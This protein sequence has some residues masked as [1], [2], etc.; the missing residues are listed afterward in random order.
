MRIRLEL[1]AWVL[2]SAAAHCQAQ[3]YSVIFTGRLLGQFRYPE[4]QQLN[5]PQCPGDLPSE[6]NDPL[7]KKFRDS[8]AE[9]DRDHQA[10]RVAVGDTFAPFFLS[11]LMYDRGRSAGERWVHKEQYEFAESQGAWVRADKLQPSDESVLLRGGGRVPA[12]NVGCF[13]RLVQFDAIVP[14][15][16]DFYFGAERLRELKGFLESSNPQLPDFY[17]PVRMLGSNLTM[18]PVRR[19]PGQPPAAAK[20][21]V[22]KPGTPEPQAVIPAVVLPWMRAIRIKNAITITPPSPAVPD[23][24]RLFKNDDEDC[25]NS[26]LGVEGARAPMGRCAQRELTLGPYT[27][28]K[29]FS[30]V[31]IAFPDRPPET[32]VPVYKGNG[33]YVDF[34]IAG[35][36]ANVP[37]PLAS[38]KLQIARTGKSSIETPINVELPY[39]ESVSSG[40]KPWASPLAAG[41]SVAVFGVVDADMGQSVGRLNTT[42]MTKNVPAA[43][44]ASFDDRSETDLRFSDPAEALAQVMQYCSTDPGCRDKRK[45]LLASMSQSKIYNLLV[46]LR[47]SQVS[48]GDMRL[49]V[50]IAEADPSRQT[51]DR[52]VTFPDNEKIPPVLVPADHTGG[53]DLYDINIRLQTARI[54]LPSGGSHDMTVRNE[55]R[56]WPSGNLL[57]HPSSVDPD[58]SGGREK[59]AQWLQIPA[60]DG[61][62][63][64]LERIALEQMHQT[65]H[66]EISLLQHRDVFVSDTML[67]LDLSADGFFAI[68]NAIY[69]KGDLIHCANFPGAAIQS[70]VR[71]S[72]QYQ[73]QEDLG[74]IGGLSA[75][76]PLALQGISAGQAFETP[77]VHG[78]YLDSKAIYGLA[79]TDFVAYGDTGY[80]SFQSAEP[81]PDPPLHKQTLFPLADIVAGHFLRPYLQAPPTGPVLTRL[82]GEDFLD[83]RS[84]A[85]PP[86]A[87]PSKQTFGN[88]LRGIGDNDELKGYDAKSAEMTA[89]QAPFLSFDLY[90]MDVGYNLFAHNGSEA[91]I[92]TTFPGV[93]STDLTPTDSASL[94]FDYSLRAQRTSRRKTLYFQSELNFG[95][96]AQRAASGA[97]TRSQTANFT[98][99]EFGLAL[100]LAPAYRNPSGWKF[101]AFP[102]SMQGQVISPRISVPFPAITQSLAKA[103]PPCPAGSV[104]VNLSCTQTSPQTVIAQHSYYVALRPGFR[105]DYVFPKPDTGGSGGGAS[106]K[107][108][109]VQVVPATY[110]TYLEFGYEGGPQL[111][112]TSAFDAETNTTTA[113]GGPCDIYGNIAEC[114]LG[115]INGLKTLFPS[116]QTPPIVVSAIPGRGYFQQGFY[117][118]FRVDMPLP[119]APKYEFVVENRGDFFLNTHRDSEIDTRLSLDL[120]TSLIVPLYGHLSLSPSFELQLFENKV[121]YSLYRSTTSYVSLTYAFDWRTGLKWREVW[122]FNNPT[123]PLSNLPNR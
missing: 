55:L 45:V 48:S 49:D 90:K 62:R 29:N 110:N 86:P 23:V 8:L 47:S 39:F 1:I 24:T 119:F 7:A 109:G 92:G 44:R 113:P 69:W 60:A 108:Q 121:N 53:Q 33:T 64:F 15:A 74:L 37:L 122:N 95:N 58:L 80:S 12:D 3:D 82:P 59:L 93:T 57:D 20:L 52:T 51:G 91:S 4:V 42:W 83:A 36:A 105:F 21:Q 56:A 116:G 68:M 97:Y 61:T 85:E 16:H 5:Q 28:T 38:L 31:S 98:Y 123:P 96:K 107:G 43:G 46:E 88:W 102:L 35:R 100:A 115:Q 118:N 103:Q 40:Q 32:L 41:G 99:Q 14:G 104:E 84:L 22:D 25:F 26:W 10:I 76:W 19:Q 81:D 75:G 72:M 112:G 18:Q 89:Q 13:L 34:W 2:Y 70:A 66:T 71:Q 94:T 9:I 63:Q 87:P 77:V 67:G 73:Q 6:A 78:Q 30:S 117:L 111:N 114:I 11:R 101:L 65:C 27:L 79:A 54:T 106:G 50:V 120:K 17:H